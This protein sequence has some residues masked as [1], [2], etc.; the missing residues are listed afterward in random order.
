M[1]GSRHSAKWITEV[2][3]SRRWIIAPVTV[4]HRISLLEA[5]GIAYCVD[6]A[7]QPC[8]NSRSA[9]GELINAIQRG[10]A[11]CATARLMCRLRTARL[12]TSAVSYEAFRCI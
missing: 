5:A 9:A 8:Q 3:V 12:R 7:V 4:F 10:D 1:A 11:G 6:L 2:V